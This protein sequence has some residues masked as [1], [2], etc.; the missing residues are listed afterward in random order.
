MDEVVALVRTHL[1][2]L[3]GPASTPHE[4]ER[5]RRIC[6]EGSVALMAASGEAQ[7]LQAVWE[8][9]AGVEVLC[10]LSWRQGC[11][12]EALL[13]LVNLTA[14][15][16]ESGGEARLAA[17]VERMAS[18]GAI[19]AAASAALA[20]GAAREGAFRVLQNATTLAVGCEAL[21]KDRP[22]LCV[23][24][25][26]AFASTCPEGATDT[27]AG[28]GE[29]LRNITAHS[30]DARKLLLRRSSKILQA[31]LP[32]LGRD[33]DARRRLGVAAALKN[34]AID[35]DN[36]FYLDDECGASLV[37]LRALADAN[38]VAQLDEADRS[39]LATALG[40]FAPVREPDPDVALLLLETLQCF[41]ATR[42]CRRRLKAINAY[43]VIRDAD[44][45]YNCAGRDP[46]EDLEEPSGVL[47]TADPSDEDDAGEEDSGVV[48]R[49]SR[50]CADLADML[51]RDE[52]ELAAE[53]VQNFE[54]GNGRG[55]R[56]PAV[57]K[58]GGDF[59]AGFLNSTS[60]S[61]GSS[62]PA[63]L[64]A[65]TRQSSGGGGGNARGGRPNGGRDASIAAAPLKRDELLNYELPD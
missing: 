63:P 29:C 51:L 58:F 3:D 23:E 47:L 16:S 11:A 32:Q 8:A 55:K 10:R 39:P 57:R 6:A 5:W 34:C 41:S 36:H 65:S 38:D 2:L 64:E 45:H 52:P 18:A 49:I 4:R 59:K 15:A 30:A 46:G 7:H 14:W 33:C 21:A 19:A 42:R 53:P 50:V 17:T 9:D 28:F 56:D 22:E 12:A 25:V 13:A 24:L 1:D 60:K 27:W 26:R 35:R 31:L 43:F 20:D 48:A 37:T 40:T 62:Q 44:L 54:Y 61:K